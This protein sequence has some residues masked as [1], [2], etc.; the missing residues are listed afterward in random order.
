MFVSDILP[1]MCP[2]ALW[3]PVGKGAKADVA[4]PAGPAFAGP[5]F[6]A[7]NAFQRVP[8]THFGSFFLELT[9]DFIHETLRMSIMHLAKV[10]KQ[11]VT[12]ISAMGRVA[13]KPKVVAFQQQRHRP[14]CT[15]AQSNQRL[16]CSISGKYK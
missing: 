11:A 13:R 6:L 9:S 3:S 14:A 10:L 4:G 8:F 16:Y 2:A 1:C 15:Y 12:E 7:E 5:T